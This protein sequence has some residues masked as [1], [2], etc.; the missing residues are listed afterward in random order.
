MHKSLSILRSEFS[1]GV[2]VILTSGFNPDSNS[3]LRSENF[4]LR[5]WHRQ[6]LEL[7]LPFKAKFEG[8]DRSCIVQI[9]P[10]WNFFSRFSSFGSSVFF[11]WQNRKSH[12]FIG[13]S[14]W[15]KF[16][17]S[18]K[19]CWMLGHVWPVAEWVSSTP[20]SQTQARQASYPI[21][22]KQAPSCFSPQCNGYLWKHRNCWW[23]LTRVLGQDTFPFLLGRRCCPLIQ[24][25]LVS[26]QIPITGAWL[27]LSR[28]SR[29]YCR[30]HTRYP[31]LLLKGTTPTPGLL[32]STAHLIN[33][34]SSGLS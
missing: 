19:S 6:F 33:I 5:S 34:S 27:M 29:S 31:A 9:L 7:S 4:H 20:V 30:P 16:W 2:D 28:D 17:P 23:V 25:S 15:L 26:W 14:N 13:P 1:K 3:R 18:W 22:Y 12:F 21:S 10:M 8:C 32:R 24:R 11:M